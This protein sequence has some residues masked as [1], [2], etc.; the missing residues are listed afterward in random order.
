MSKGRKLGQKIDNN[1]GLRH[2][3]AHLYMV[4][5]NTMASLCCP[6]F[7]CFRV[8]P[9]YEGAKTRVFGSKRRELGQKIANLL[10]LK[11]DLA[12]LFMVAWH[13][14]DSLCCPIFCVF[15]GHPMVGR[16]RNKGFRVKTTQTWPKN[17]KQPWIGAEFGTLVHG[18]MAHHG[19]I[20]L[21]HFFCFRAIP[22]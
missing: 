12:H 8:T 11:Q 17:S 7:L 15:Q 6:I 3:L 19:F 16:C 10:G 20:V 4:A 1:L 21:S 2:D 5:W 14:M 18:G 22:R 13:T 9:W